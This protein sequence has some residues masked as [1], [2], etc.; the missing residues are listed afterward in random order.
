MSATPLTPFLPVKINTGPWVA[1]YSLNALRERVASDRIVLPICSL[2]TP[3]GDLAQLAPLV[4]PPLYHEAMDAE[5]AASLV[6]QIR[7]CFPFY[8]GTQRRRD[9]RGTVQVVEL[10]RR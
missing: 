8:E 5:L 6:S 9:F 2:G 1:G 3:A 7:R 4:L 10:P